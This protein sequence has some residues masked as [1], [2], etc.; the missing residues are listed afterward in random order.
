ME[1]GSINF[2][3]FSFDFGLKY[4]PAVLCTTTANKLIFMTIRRLFLFVFCIASLSSLR[5]QDIHYT[6]FDLA[7]MKLNPAN[8]GAF[9]GTA[10]L[11][12]IF[13]DQWFTV[14]DDEFRSPSFG[15]DAPI[16]KGFRDQDWVGVGFQ[17]VSDRVGTGRLGEGSQGGRYR[18]SGALFSASYHLGLDKKGNR[19]LTLGLQGGSM[20]REIDRNNSGQIFFDGITA[21]QELGLEVGMGELDNLLGPERDFNASYFDVNA[22]LLYKQKDPKEGTEL[23]LGVA[24]AHITQPDESFGGAG[25]SM[26][27][28]NTGGNDD[29]KRAMTLTLHGNYIYPLT[30]TI[31]IEP[32]FLFQTASGSENNIILQGMAGYQ[33]NDQIKLRGGLGYRVGDAGQ[34]LLGAV[35][36]EALTVGFAYDINLSQLR[37]VSSAQGAFELGATY[38]LKLYKEPEIKPTILCP[39]F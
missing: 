25:G 17:F 23:Q 13:R 3:Y 34:I 31:S 37:S 27:G 4:Y 38:I 6:L 18:T 24:V 21:A 1:S 19:T 7:P 5:G 33:L 36:D 30:E 26:G 29:A 8:T 11:S 39:R 10:R 12:G 35:I 28:P 9:Y 2:F 14:L 32:A 16:I 20:S 22:G 15:I